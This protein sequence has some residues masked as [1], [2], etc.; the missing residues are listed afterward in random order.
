LE[1]GEAPWIYVTPRLKITD[2]QGLEVAER[3]RL[4]HAHLGNVRIAT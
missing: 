4:Q 2:F 3:N 1:N